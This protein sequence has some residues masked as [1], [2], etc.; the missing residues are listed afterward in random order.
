M[1]PPA[2]A[3][4]AIVIDAA[5]GRHNRVLTF[6]LGAKAELPPLKLVA[7]PL[8]PPPAMASTEKVA[9]GKRLFQT[10]CMYCHGD[11]AVSGG[12]VPDLRFSTTLASSDAWKAIV[13]DGTLSKNGMVSFAKHLKADDVET[14]RTY[15][16]QRAHDEKKRLASP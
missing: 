14:L 5:P 16:I 2:N 9:E 11:T 6:K 7:R 10:Y 13:L 12:T 1:Q 4:G 3:A 15:V 8:D